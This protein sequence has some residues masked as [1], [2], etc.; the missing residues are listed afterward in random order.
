MA[1]LARLSIGGC[2]H[3]VVQRSAARPIV[4]DAAQIKQ[5]LAVLRQAAV[6]SSV[7]LHAYS[8][9]SQGLWLVATPSDGA[10][11][12]RMMQSVGR[13]YVRWLNDRLG[14]GGPLFGGRF[15]AAILEPESA[16]LDAMRFVETRPVVLGGVESPAGYS[17]SSYR[18]HVGLSADAAV[19]DHPLYWALGNTPFERQAAYR[20]LVEAPLPAVTVDELERALKGGWAVGSV[21]FKSRIEPVSGR[22]VSR[23]RPGRPRGRP[24]SGG[25]AMH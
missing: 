10:A 13:R 22:R 1:R 11:V 18:H 23:A 12:G 14:S 8:V 20:A 15:R 16:L 7:A 6:E 21:S 5:L 24:E 17:W 9:L 2:P 19:Q 3:L 4:S 25:S